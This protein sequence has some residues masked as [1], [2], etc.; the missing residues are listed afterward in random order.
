MLILSRKKDE[1]LIINGNI[2]IKIISSEDGKVKLGIEAPKEVEIHRKE[3]F[4]KIQAENRMAKEAPAQFKAL[5]DL[6]KK[7][8]THIK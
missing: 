8:S 2:E 3:V 4:E 1:S 7:N 6:M 5:S